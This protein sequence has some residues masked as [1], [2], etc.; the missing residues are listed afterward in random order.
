VATT[1]NV[2]FGYDAAGQRTSMS[3]GMGS[4]TYN[5]NNLA[6]LTSFLQMLCTAESSGG[7]SLSLLL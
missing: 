6:R 5:Y 3:D 1:A 2:S 7:D 4:V